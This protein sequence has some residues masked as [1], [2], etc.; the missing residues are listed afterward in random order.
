MKGEIGQNKG[1]YFEE[2]ICDKNEGKLLEDSFGDDDDSFDKG[3]N[4][5][6]K[7]ENSFDE[8]EDCFDKGE[9]CFNDDEYS[10]NE[11]GNSFDK[12]EA[13]FEEGF[14]DEIDVN[15]SEDRQKSNVVE[16]LKSQGN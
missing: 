5:F 4:S 9:D 10:F 3:E 14:D 15:H 8:E 2:E 1:E 16:F 11:G 7:G 6:D 12:G 13:N